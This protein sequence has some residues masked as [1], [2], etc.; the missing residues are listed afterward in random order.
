[1]TTSF[2]HFA[3]GHLLAS[4]Y[5]QPFAAGLAGATAVAFWVTGYCLLTGKP[6]YRLL[7]RLPTGPTVFTLLMLWLLSWGYKILLVAG[8]HDGW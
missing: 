5:T 6:A 1:M 3:H 4:F 2:A 7:R 8:G